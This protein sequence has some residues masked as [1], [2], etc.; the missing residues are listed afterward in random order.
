MLQSLRSSLTNERFSIL[1]H[2]LVLSRIEFSPAVLHGVDECEIKKLQRVIKA[3]FRSTFKLK[4]RDRISVKMKEKG[5]LSIKQRIILR[6]LLITHTTFISGKPEYL[7]KLIT[8]STSER[9]SRSQ[10]S[11]DLVAHGAITKIGS[12]RF[13]VAAPQVWRHIN[14]DIRKLPSHVVFRLAAKKCITNIMN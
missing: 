3:T 9:S 14:S 1:A 4:K 5:W 12:R 7:R 13:E 11:F 10:A 8:L 6:L 2:A